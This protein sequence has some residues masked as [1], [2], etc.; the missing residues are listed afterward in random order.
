MYDADGRCGCFDVTE[1]AAAPVFLPIIRKL[2]H[3]E[4]ANIKKEILCSPFL[5]EVARIAFEKV[6]KGIRRRQR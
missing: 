3:S 2:R 4:T 6:P 5:E 1:F